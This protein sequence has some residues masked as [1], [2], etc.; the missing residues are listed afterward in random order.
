VILTGGGSALLPVPAEPLSVGDLREVTAA[1]LDAGASIDELNAV[2]KH[3]SAVKGGRLAERAS[4]AT[5]LG[6]LISDVVGDDPSVIASGPLSPDR[7]TYADAIEILSEYDVT[8][9]RS[10][11]EYLGRGHRGEFAETPGPES[12]VFKRISTYILAD[13]ETALRAAARRARSEGYTTEIISG[14]VEGEAQ[15]VGRSH[16]N[17]ALSV[18]SESDPVRPPAVLL[19]GGETTV[20][21]E[22]DG[23]GGPNQEVAVGAGLRL[24]DAA[25]SAIVIASV[26]TDGIDGASEAAG[27]L[28]DPASVEA[29]EIAE[30]ALRT[31]STTDYLA[32]RRGLLLTGFTGT[33]VNDLRV[34]VVGEHSAE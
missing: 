12:S 25:A 20:S 26:D 17:R 8:G 1:L 21:V 33:N 10:V 4:P 2:R 3:L 7:T 28:V 22:G 16:A 18:R 23:S 15:N 24:A 31:N 27:G 9:P 29:P 34:I 30:E 11:R 13:N 14:E 6:L 19:S 32:A 5:V